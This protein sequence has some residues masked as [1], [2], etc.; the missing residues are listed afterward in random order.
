MNSGA[1]LTATIRVTAA[2]CIAITAARTPRELTARSPERPCGPSADTTASR[3]LTA[4]TSS[5]GESESTTATCSR[6]APPTGTRSHSRTAAPLR[7]ES[8][9][10]AVT[11]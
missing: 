2:S 3:P 8:R 6:P 5:P 7:A 11:S 10:T 4:P 1:A 9:I